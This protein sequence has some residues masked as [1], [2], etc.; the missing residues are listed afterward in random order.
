MGRLSTALRLCLHQ[1]S[2]KLYLH[3]EA[4]IG[5]FVAQCICAVVEEC[6]VAL[7]LPFETLACSRAAFEVYPASKCSP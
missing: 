1:C 7:A 2:L 4:R 6:I 5:P 3:F